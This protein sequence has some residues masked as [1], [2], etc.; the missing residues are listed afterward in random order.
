ME[1]WRHDQGGKVRERGRSCTYRVIGIYLRHEIRKRLDTEL[2][3]VPR[4]EIVRSTVQHAL[5][6]QVIP[7]GKH[8][9]QRGGNGCHAAGG[10]ERSFGALERRE[11]A[12]EGLVVRRVVEA[13]VA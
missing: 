8:C 7:G 11:L 13:D 10:D 3:E 1:A 4:D 6:Q 9:E 2:L 5:C 12:V